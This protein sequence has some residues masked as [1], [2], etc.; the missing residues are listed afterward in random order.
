V[1]KILELFEAFV[2]MQTLSDEKWKIY[3]GESFHESGAK[4]NNY[5][6]LV[7]LKK[8]EIPSQFFG[9]ART[10]FTKET[11]VEIL[12]TEKF[13]TVRLNLKPHQKQGFET[14]KKYYLENKDFGRTM[15]QQGKK[16]SFMFRDEDREKFYEF[17]NDYVFGEGVCVLV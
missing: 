4:I 10:T 12:Y 15:D 1:E 14:I 3:Q 13:I 16:F 17:F 6:R 9:L 2:L 8:E 11:L 5:I 7:E